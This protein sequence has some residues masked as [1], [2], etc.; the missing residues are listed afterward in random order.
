MA[1]ALD[2][3][4]V[5]DGKKVAKSRTYVAV[6]LPGNNHQM[7]LDAISRRSWWRASEDKGSTSFELWWGGNGQ[8]FDWASSS[9][10]KGCDK[11]VNKMSVHS[12]ICVK[13]RLAHN[14]RRYARA[15][16][17][18]IATLVPATFVLAGG[19]GADTQLNELSAF[20]NACAEA[21]SRGDKLWIVKPGSGNRGHGIK[22]CMSGKAVEAHLRE[23][24]TGVPHV[25]QKYIERPL[26]VA[27]RKFDI[28]QFVLVTHD[29]RVFAYRDSYVRTC[30][31]AYA[32]GNPDDLSSHLTNDFVQKTLP[33][34][35]A[36]EDGNKLSFPQLDAVLAEQARES[37]GKALSVDE[38]IWPQMT[39]IIS[40]VFSCALPLF[41]GAPSHG[42][43]FEL[44]GLD[45]MLTADGHVQLL[46]VNTSPALFQRGA[47]LT[48]TLP[49]LIEELV[50]KAIDPS[51]PPPPGTDKDALPTPLDRFERV[52]VAPPPG[53]GAAASAAKAAAAARSAPIGAP[54][55]TGP[56][57]RDAA[58]A[59]SS[60]V[61][62][63]NKASLTHA[64]SRASHPSYQGH[65][66]VGSNT[67]I[68]I[69]FDQ[70]P[71]RI[72]FAAKLGSYVKCGENNM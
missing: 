5:Q 38:D 6:V 21:A 58:L 36:F 14:L 59:R 44:Y 61:G 65:K 72:T 8:P 39:R 48:S 49:L 9:L 29:Y 24:K 10:S 37:G 67:F 40:H 54:P 47:Y 3:T 1:A 63:T 13:A 51:F 18:D 41:G 28:R 55:A 52:E 7:L 15:A 50:Q 22:L 32:A 42:C 11:L 34:F 33:S 46:E 2:R 62:A 60:R 64:R 17:V 53:V 20:R 31:A 68:E 12:E 4:A 19:K 56:S 57:T 70:V 71:L 27:G 26:L 69:P 30:S 25:V 45:F 43:S 66:V 35:G 16:K 23:G